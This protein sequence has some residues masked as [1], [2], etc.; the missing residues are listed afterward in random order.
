MQL[1][2]LIETILSLAALYAVLSVLTSSIQEMLAGIVNRRGRTLYRAIDAMLGQLGPDF[3]M[4][5][6]LKTPEIA[7]LGRLPIA[8]VPKDNAIATSK[9]DRTPQTAKQKLPSYID[10]AAFARAVVEMLRKTSNDSTCPLAIRL[11]SLSDRSATDNDP[12]IREVATWFKSN[13]ERASGRYARR[14]KTWLLIVGTILSAGLNADSIRLTSGI[15]HEEPRRRAALELSESIRLQQSK[16]V[17]AA[18]TSTDAAVDRALTL[19]S[20]NLQQ[21]DQTKQLLGWSVANRPNSKL[22]VI[23]ALLGWILTGAAISFGAP[24]WFDVLNRVAN[25]RAGGKPPK[26][27]TLMPSMQL[28]IGKEDGPIEITA[29]GAPQ[30]H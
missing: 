10:D 17:V 16:A 13:M 5:R 8:L 6:F 18:D 20:N 28:S 30:G 9:A 26:S 3:Y 29:S 15:Y 2:S 7:S 12:A 24:F 25:L 14:T 23:V 21:D 1:N 4:E 27:E 19:L 11:R 22:A